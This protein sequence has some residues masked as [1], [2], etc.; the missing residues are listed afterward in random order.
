M[1]CLS[2]IRLLIVRSTSV[3]LAHRRAMYALDRQAEQVS[4]DEMALSAE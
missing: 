3:A 2:D 1:A 4:L